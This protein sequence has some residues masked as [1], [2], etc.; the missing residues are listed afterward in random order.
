M[1]PNAAIFEL[2][3]PEVRQDDI[4]PSLALHAREV[5]IAALDTETTG[6]EWEKASLRT[7]QVFVPGQPVEIVQVHA[8][9]RPNELIGLLEDPAVRKLFHNAMFDL[10][11][12]VSTWDLLPTSVRCTKVASKIMWPGD[13]GRQSLK[14]LT[15]HLLNVDLDKTQQTSDWSS[16]TL[17]SE[18]IAYAADD[19]LYLIPLLQ[20]LEGQLRNAGLLGLAEQCWAHLPARVALE[21]SHI[22]DPFSY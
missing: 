4:S 10:R 7:V 11:F 17:T 12:L 18:Q 13:V 8:A 19:V 6:L 1:E 3:A 21:L 2:R 5:G 14:A 20:E 9:N 15:R 16:S 22:P